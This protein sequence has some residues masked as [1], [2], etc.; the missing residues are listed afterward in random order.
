M[1]RFI[2]FL[3]TLSC[4]VC[5]AL[6]VPVSAESPSAVSGAEFTDLGIPTEKHFPNSGN[7]VYARTVWG[8]EVFNGKL[9]IGCGDYDKNA[10]SNSSYRY[11]PLFAYGLKT[12]DWQLEAKLDD[13][14]LT[15]F[16]KANNTLYIAGTDPI[17]GRD[18][19]IYY[20]VPERDIWRTAVQPGGAAH[21]FDLL[22]T[23]NDMT[24]YAGVGLWEG[25]APRVPISKNGGKT[26]P[27]ANNAYWFLILSS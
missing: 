24:V 2:C 17:S 22:F 27:A 19:H 12:G 23:E 25:D 14:Q 13:E 18:G 15:R 9:Y 6:T 1:K 10:G 16:F 20:Y 7:Y 26:F 4:L 5:T 8:M 11:M 21:I 3:L